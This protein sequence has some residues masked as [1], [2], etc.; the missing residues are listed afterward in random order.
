M[1][2]YGLQP[3]ANGSGQSLAFSGD[4]M[5]AEVTGQPRGHHLLIAMDVIVNLEAGGLHL[6]AGQVNEQDIPVADGSMVAGLAMDDG[7]RCLGIGE[8]ICRSYAESVQ[9]FFIGLVAPAQ[10]VVKMHYPCRIGFP[11]ADGVTDD[12]P[13]GVGRGSS[14]VIG[15]SNHWGAGVTWEMR[16]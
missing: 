1:G 10:Q 4:G 5:D 3:A 6:S 9:G 7:Q 15:R 13:R 12:Q 14:V 8:D 2:S 11:K 16:G